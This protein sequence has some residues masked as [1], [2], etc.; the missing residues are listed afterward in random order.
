MPRKLTNSNNGLKKARAN[1]TKRTLIGFGTFLKLISEY[2][3]F[4]QSGILQLH[5]RDLCISIYR[6]I[7]KEYALPRNRV[8][9]P[10]APIPEDLRIRII[11]FLE[12]CVASRAAIYHRDQVGFV[13]E[14]WDE[15]AYRKCCQKHGFSEK[16]YLIGWVKEESTEFIRG[17]KHKK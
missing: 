10:A 6:P 11:S 15:E 4:S 12:D 1:K 7:K 13:W 14:V 17:A 2:I 9:L 16:K 5:L 3:D 8:V